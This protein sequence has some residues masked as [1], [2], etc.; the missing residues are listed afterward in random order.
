[1][2][3]QQ[4][5]LEILRKTRQDICQNRRVKLHLPMEIRYYPSLYDSYVGIKW[6]RLG[7]GLINQ[8]GISCHRR[9]YL[10]GCSGS[11]RGCAYIYSCTI[12]TQPEQ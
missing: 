2:T 5:D 1:M 12:T 3:G 10:Y 6:Q 8:C 9:V 7:L 4:E 11:Q